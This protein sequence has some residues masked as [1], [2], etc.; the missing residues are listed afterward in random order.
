MDEL[1]YDDW[2]DGRRA[3]RA[4][5]PVLFATWLT[6]RFIPNNYVGVV[7]KLWSAKGSV[8][9][10]HI[11]ALNGEAGYQADLLRG[12]IHFGLWRWQYRV[13]LCSL[14]TVPQGKIG[15]VYARD[16]QPLPPN[17]TLGRTVNATTSRTPARSSWGKAAACLTK[18]GHCPNTPA[19]AAANSRSSR[20]R[21]YA[22]NPALFVVITQDRGLLRCGTIACRGRRLTAVR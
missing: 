16:G 22:I 9:E 8:P 3:H 1:R 19:I 18:A 15:Y 21:S 13:H 6:L 11:L 14:V 7:E 20:R 5:V 4:D 2:H 17:Q 10:G 12:G